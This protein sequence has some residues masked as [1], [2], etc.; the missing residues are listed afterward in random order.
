MATSMSCRSMYCNQL[1]GA[2]VGLR[3]KIDARPSAIFC[4]QIGERAGGAIAGDI[5]NDQNAFVFQAAVEA[6]SKCIDVEQRLGHVLA[7]V[8][9]RRR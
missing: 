3:N 5:T 1:V 2:L 4:E 9:F 8:R 7:G 6:V